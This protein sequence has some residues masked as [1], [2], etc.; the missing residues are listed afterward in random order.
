MLKYQ[1]VSQCK[2]IVSIISGKDHQ[3]IKDLIRWLRHIINNLFLAF[4]L[5][6]KKLIVF[7]IKISQVNIFQHQDSQKSNQIFIERKRRY[8]HFQDQANRNSIILVN[9]NNKK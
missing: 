6:G 9:K 2:M 7:I 4:C 5:F 3:N 8:L 1:E